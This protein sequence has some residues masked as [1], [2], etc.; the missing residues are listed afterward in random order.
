MPITTRILRAS[1]CTQRFGR[2]GWN[3]DTEKLGEPTST[4]LQGRGAAVLWDGV[5]FEGYKD[6]VPEDRRLYI[7]NN[8]FEDEETRR[9]LNV[10][11]VL[12]GEE[13]AE[14]QKPHAGALPVK[15]NGSARQF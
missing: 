9:F 10:A 11:M 12:M 6:E 15:V 1:G 3:P 2:I 13:G 14:D 8:E 5:T 4:A 7:E